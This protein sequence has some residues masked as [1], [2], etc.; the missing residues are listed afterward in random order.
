MDQ[1]PIKSTVGLCLEPGVVWIV[2]VKLRLNDEAQGL[3]LRDLPCRPDT[4]THSEDTQ[5]ARGQ[6][7]AGHRPLTPEHRVPRTRLLAE[8][9][10]SAES[11][12]ACTC[13]CV[14]VFVNMHALLCTHVYLLCEH[15]CVR[16]LWIVHVHK[17][18]HVCMRVQVHVCV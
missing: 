11:V 2:A 12:C 13:V 5:T 10:S 4:L 14:H 18:V 8:D 16:T 3:S 9:L 17:C 1:P 7:E 6:A 15:M